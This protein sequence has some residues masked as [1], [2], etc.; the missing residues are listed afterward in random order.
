MTNGPALPSSLPDLAL[1]VLCAVSQVR[2]DGDLD[3]VIGSGEGG[4]W[5]LEE[6]L[7]ELT[8]GLYIK[9]ERKKESSIIA[10]VLT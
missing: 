4:K 3:Y 2:D 7:A 8:A 10:R 9:G 6:E 1:K 5:N